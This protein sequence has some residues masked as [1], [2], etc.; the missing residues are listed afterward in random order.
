MLTWNKVKTQPTQAHTVVSRSDCGRFEIRAKFHES[1]R[2]FAKIKTYSIIMLGCPGE[3]RVKEFSYGHRT[4][5]EAQRTA[6]HAVKNFDPA[7]VAL[8]AES[9]RTYAV[10]NAARDA[11]NN[12]SRA[13]KAFDEA[14]VAAVNGPQPE[15]PS[16]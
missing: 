11:C 1:M 2:R 12:A 5:V 8:V 13:L 6:E 4:I 16:Y 3:P 9:F 14:A 15:H 7:R 10:L